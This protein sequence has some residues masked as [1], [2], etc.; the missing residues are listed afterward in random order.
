MTILKALLPVSR[1][2]TLLLTLVATAATGRAALVPKVQTTKDFQ[3]DSV[4]DSDGNFLL[5]WKFN[6]TH[7]TFE[8]HVKTKG[9]L[10]C[11]MHCFAHI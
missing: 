8:A 11:F 10:E 2:W 1:M 6:D 4:L 9:M 7:V 5:F 3:Q